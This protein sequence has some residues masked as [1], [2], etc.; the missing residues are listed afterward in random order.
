MRVDVGYVDHDPTR[1][2]TRARR[3]GQSAPHRVQPEPS[4]IRADLGMYHDS[5]TVLD[6]TSRR[7]SEHLDEEVVSRTDV[8]VRNDRD[9]I[10]NEVPHVDKPTRW[11]RPTRTSGRSWAQAERANEMVEEVEAR[12]DD[13]PGGP[14]GVRRGHRR[15]GH[16]V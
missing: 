16:A 6:D 7:E 1:R 10:L 12:F 14:S 9:H 5:V 15:H 8:R 13:D 3:S 2:S 11:P 4:V